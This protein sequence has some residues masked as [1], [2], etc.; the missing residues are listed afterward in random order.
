MASNIPPHNLSEVAEAVKRLVDDPELT[1]NDLCETVLGPDFPGGG[2]IYRLEEQKN[3]ETGAIER[4]DAI[5]RAYANGRGRIL[6]RAKAHVEDG[7]GG[8]QSIIVTEL[9]YAVNKASLIEKIADL[10][11][12]K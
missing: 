10:G 1:N 3:I 8:P 5:R 6:M 2:V 11:Q 4:V 12:S 9:P 7:K